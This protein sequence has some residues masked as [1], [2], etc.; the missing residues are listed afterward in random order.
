MGAV[1]SRVR[2]EQIV[3]NM[4][5]RIRESK[6]FLPEGVQYAKTQG[7]GVSDGGRRAT[8]QDFRR[9]LYVCVNTIAKRVAA[10]PW[11][12]GEVKGASANVSK[13]LAAMS[14]RH[15]GSV[16]EI[17]DH[18]CLD[19]LWNP[20]E[21]QGKPE[22][23]Y[24]TVSN[25][26]LTG[27]WFWVGGFNK[28]ENRWVMTA[29]PTRWMTP[30]HTP[31]PFASYELKSPHMEKPMSLS[32]EQVQ[33]GYLPDPED[34]LRAFCPAD[35]VRQ[36]LLIESHMV[37]AQ[38]ESMRRGI[39][40][41]LVLTVGKDLDVDGKDIGRPVL[42]P[43]QR[44]QLIM[45][46]REVWGNSQNYG[47][48]A[49]LDGMIERVDRIS[50]SAQEMDF[51][52]SEE[53]LKSRIFQAYGI[54]A[55]IVGAA[56]NANRAQAVEA[57]RVA[58]SIVFNPII[59]AISTAMTEWVGPAFV[60]PARLYAWLEPCEPTDSDLEL[61]QWSTALAKGVVT[62]DEYRANILGLAPKEG[63]QDARVALLDTAG[64]LQS[65]SMLVAQVAKGELPAEQA[66][67]VLQL[68]LNIKPSEADAIVGGNATVE[69]DIQEDD[70]TRLYD[71]FDVFERNVME[72][73]RCI[74]GVGD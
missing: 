20:N 14:K 33:Y 61:K 2:S 16:E 73:V 21:V 46:I 17:H 54:N 53:I 55:F 44:R 32:K 41:N 60:D 45:A 66:S 52:V 22:F 31:T 24:M 62:S 64:G 69:A 59:D 40:P 6:A 26:L 43:E 37:N 49:I 57:E 38:T 35:A 36:T 71:A 65:V 47:D 7:Y 74:T 10:Q 12:I 63:G 11:K 3:A 25:L 56:D 29:V 19:A 68:F 30:I 23:V 51:Q 5:A 34:P 9:W 13:R 4:R 58:C 27:W 70:A 8:Y 42:T 15:D 50:N 1:E 39:H 67:R 28:K 48:P 18:P 72:K